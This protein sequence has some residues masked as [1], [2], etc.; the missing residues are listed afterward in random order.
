M[1]ESIVI[2]Y[3]RLYFVAYEETNFVA[4][5]YFDNILDKETELETH[6]KSLDVWG[7]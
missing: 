5:K 3:H 2:S 6:V 7:G 4:L 1:S